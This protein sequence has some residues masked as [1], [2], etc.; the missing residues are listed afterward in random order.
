LAGVPPLPTRN[1]WN[2]QAFPAHVVHAV[3]LAL[4]L[5]QDVPEVNGGHLVTVNNAFVRHLSD[6]TGVAQELK[7]ISKFKV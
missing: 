5:L 3:V 1:R 6:T 7:H 2:S 4:S